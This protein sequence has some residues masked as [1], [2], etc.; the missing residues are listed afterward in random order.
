[1]NTP[2]LI[3]ALH[4][5]CRAPLQLGAHLTGAMLVRLGILCL[6]LFTAIGQLVHQTRDPRLVLA[7]ADL[8]EKFSQ[9]V[10]LAQLTTALDAEASGAH[11]LSLETYDGLR[12]GTCSFEA[13]PELAAGRTC[14]QSTGDLLAAWLGLNYFEAQRRIDD[15]HLLI[16]R[17]TP[18]GT[19]CEPRF[20]QL[21]EVY[22]K[23]GADRRSI[24]ATARRLEKLEATDTTFDGVPTELKA[25]GTDGRF[26][27]EHA[28]E[29]LRSLGPDEAR[30]DI[31]SRISLYKQLKGDKLPPKLGL[32]IGPV[33]QGVHEFTLRT[34]AT[35]AQLIR[36]IAVQAS[37]PRTK[38]GQAAR[39]PV[40]P[41]GST[42]AADQPAT[43]PTAARAAES[44]ESID[45]SGTAEEPT[46]G[47]PTW[48]R[49]ENP[50][51]DW[52]RAAEEPSGA[53]P[54]LPADDAEATPGKSIPANAEVAAD[55]EEVS[56]A[57]R[58]L[59]AL[60][61]ILATPAGGKA[62]AVIPRFI[63]YMWLSD[64]QNLDRA[65][66]TTSN[67]VRLPPGEL[68]RALA[69]ANVIPVVLGGNSQPLDMGRSRRYHE[70]YVRAG[71]L[72]RDRGCIVPGCTTA[73]DHVEIDHY[74]LPWA[75]G[76]TTSV[77]SGAAVC[78]DG[79]HSRHLGQ[80]KIVD[81]NG[82]PHVILPPHLDPEQK[83]R[84]NT[85]WDAL[86]LG[87]APDPDVAGPEPP[88]ND[89]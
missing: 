29:S 76:G 21:A 33:V 86:Q 58:R 51:P 40:Q 55:R 37:A 36:S 3:S 44:A 14:Y 75:E 22:A 70:G 84:R 39:T 88:E 46:A 4:T 41:D 34:L 72:A 11:A 78:P 8:V 50:M 2:A 89:E 53:K 74:K 87:D 45:R 35:Q 62:K 20:A 28:A 42:E 69:K 77:K 65:Y 38:A 49:T 13:Q 59:N 10:H 24:A 79:H 83:P 12:D 82:L 31:S 25:R 18:Q 9:Q 68:R 19:I 60:M 85:Y 71:V 23:G 61:A 27:E 16:G 6:A 57:L 7:H 54:E 47:A 15:A 30:K 73:P 43:E 67:G 80:L 17:R 56:V 52:A 5:L 48:L 1:M 26:L 66:G 63:V 64:L 32:F 81:V